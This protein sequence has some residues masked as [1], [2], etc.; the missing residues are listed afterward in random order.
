MEGERAGHRKESILGKEGVGARGVTWGGRSEMGRGRE[1][2]LQR[3]TSL[4][5]K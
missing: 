4:H 1:G 3:K 2:I 5:T